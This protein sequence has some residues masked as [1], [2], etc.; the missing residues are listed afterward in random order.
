MAG[1]SQPVKRGFLAVVVECPVRLSVSSRPQF[2][3]LPA[4]TR[5]N[6]GKQASVQCRR[7]GVSVYVMS[8]SR[9]ASEWY[10]TRGM[11]NQCRSGGGMV[12]GVCRR[13]WMVL[14]R[15][16]RVSTAGSSQSLRANGLQRAAAS[17]RADNTGTTRNGAGSPR[18]AC[19]R[20]VSP[21]R[22]G[23]SGLVSL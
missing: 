22:T 16:V 20:R 5:R 12:C 9:E 10:Q 23:K 19:L 21:R 18:A 8:V 17:K 4:S 15:C 1:R 6:S 11:R 3:R 14:R 13:A 7:N 2:S